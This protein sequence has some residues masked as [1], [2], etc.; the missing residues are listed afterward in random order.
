MGEN[1]PNTDNIVPEEKVIGLRNVDV[2]LYQRF[3]ARC[4]VLG[5]EHGLGFEQAVSAWLAYTEPGGDI[6][7]Q[8]P[9]SCQA[10][11]PKVLDEFRARCKQVKLDVTSGIIKAMVY[12][13][14]GFAFTDPLPETDPRGKGGKT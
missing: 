3:K 13:I 5:L 2:E 7:T 9:F 14:H 1:E 12:W 8:P 11:S 4:A 10:V 6:L